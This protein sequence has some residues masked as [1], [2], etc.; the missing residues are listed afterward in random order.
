MVGCMHVV[1]IVSYEK[2]THSLDYVAI[3]VSNVL[4][5]MLGK[6]ECSFFFFFYFHFY[7]MR[8]IYVE[9]SDIWCM[10]M[11]LLRVINKLYR[12]MYPFEYVSFKFYWR[13]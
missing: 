10:E 2:S 4:M 6:R 7:E 9:L 3:I 13:Y 8:Y 11:V 1:L 12:C 5:F